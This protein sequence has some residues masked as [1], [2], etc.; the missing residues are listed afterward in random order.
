[1]AEKD[2]KKCSRSLVI[3]EM[4]IKTTM[5]FQLTPVRMVEIKNKTK[6]NKTKQNKT[7]N[8]NCWREYGERRTCLYFWCDFKLVH[9]L[10]KLIWQFLRK[11]DIEDPELYPAYTQ[12]MLQHVIRT[13]ALL[14]S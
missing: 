8:S 14:C 7:K 2:L 9:P 1:M 4:Q 11:L 10:W 13:H 3:R 5:R 6:Q 12:K